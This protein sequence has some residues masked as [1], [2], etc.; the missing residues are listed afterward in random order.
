LSDQSEELITRIYD[1][2]VVRPI[3]IINHKRCPYMIFWALGVV[4]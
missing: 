4:S 2:F 3:V 1:I